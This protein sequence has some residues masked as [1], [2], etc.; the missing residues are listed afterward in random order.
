MQSHKAREA[1]NK[2]IAGVRLK[3]VLTVI[4]ALSVVALPQILR[5]SAAPVAPQGI[6]FR[7]TTTDDHNDFVCDAADCTF[8]EAIQ[9]ANNLASEDTIDFSLTGVINLASALPAIN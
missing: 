1:D 4:T 9:A 5:A 6:L 7:V 8:R 3:L 2:T